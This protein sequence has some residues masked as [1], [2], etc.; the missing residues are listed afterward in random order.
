MVSSDMSGPMVSSS[1][2]GPM[3]S[4]D[5][6]GPMVSSDMSGP[7]STQIRVSPYC[8]LDVTGVLSMDKCEC[9]IR[10]SDSNQNC[11]SSDMLP[12]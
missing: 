7:I 10:Q 8:T 4:S 5:M 3:V 11:D 6:N 12:F 1:M 2:S 9:S